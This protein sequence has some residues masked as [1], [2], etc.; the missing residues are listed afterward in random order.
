M[1]QNFTIRPFE[2]TD[3]D[4]AVGVKLVNQSW[5]NDPSTVE[6]WKHC[7]N[8]RNKDYMNR[9]FLG[10]IKQENATQI[11]AIGFCSESISSK[12]TGK[13]YIDFYIEQA[14]EKQGLDEP[15]YTYLVTALS[16]KKLRELQTGTREDNVHRIEFLQ[17]QGFQQVM[18]SPSSEL[19]VLGFDFAP[20][21]R[22]TEKVVASGIEIVTAQEL[23]VRDA[24]WMQKLYDLDMAIEQDMPS[25]NEFTPIGIDE[26]ARNFKSHNIRT[27][28]WFVAVDGEDYVG[29]S[30]LWPNL[31]REDL[32]IVGTTGVLPSHRRRGIATALKL[33]TIAFVQAFGAGI[34]VTSNE[35]NNPMYDL[36]L[37]LGFKPT[38]AWL[39]F[40]KSCKESTT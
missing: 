19:N 3:L 18:R 7:Y 16:D 15:L 36:N 32:F 28:A 23:Q 22:Y 31:V 13:Y 9:R 26:F 37:K 40:E 39:T 38:P 10:E 24:N 14:F 33:K 1:K 17:A 11:V 29:I 35:E 30:S 8:N 34:I 21:A 6:I 25:T 20:F 5:P 4:Y 12:K 2:Y 27:D